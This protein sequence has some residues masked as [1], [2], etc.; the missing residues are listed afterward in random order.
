MKASGE[1]KAVE[2]T[3]ERDPRVTRAL[4]LQ[5]SLEVVNPS[6]SPQRTSGGMASSSSSSSAPGANKSSDRLNRLRLRLGNTLGDGS[7]TDTPES[8]I[9]PKMIDFARD[10]AVAIGPTFTIEDVARADAA[11]PESEDCCGCIRR[12]IGWFTEI[13]V[14]SQTPLKHPADRHR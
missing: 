1:A 12:A 11:T 9:P 10:A 2:P 14:A 8:P 13:V 4:L 6:S 5:R 3:P 7:G